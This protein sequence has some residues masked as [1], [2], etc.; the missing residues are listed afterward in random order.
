MGFQGWI[1][2]VLV[3]FYSVNKTCIYIGWTE[4]VTICCSVLG[5]V[6]LDRRLFCFCI[7]QISSVLNRDAFYIIFRKLC[8]ELLKTIGVNSTSIG[9]VHLYFFAKCIC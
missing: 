9:F 5:T 8:P 6:G 2:G 7:E 3:S 1:D 4:C